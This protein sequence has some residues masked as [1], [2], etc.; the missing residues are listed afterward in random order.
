VIDGLLI[1]S[2]NDEYW[3]QEDEDDE[4]LDSPGS[5]SYLL[6]DYYQHLDIGVES[7][8]EIPLPSTLDDMSQDYRDTVF[9]AAKVRDGQLIY[10][11]E[12]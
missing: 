12:E 8:V 11:S 2:D 7:P 4:P 6:L 5:R 1:D 10:M 9:F 3:P